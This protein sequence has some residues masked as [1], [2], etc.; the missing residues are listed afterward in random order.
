MQYVVLLE[1]ALSIKHQAELSCNESS[2]ALDVIK[3]LADIL[4]KIF[5]LV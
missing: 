4:L 3:L 2:N 1:I 5:G